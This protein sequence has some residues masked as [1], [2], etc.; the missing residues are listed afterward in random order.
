MNKLS[1]YLD[2]EVT[3]KLSNGYK[4]Q[5]LLQH[6][7]QNEYY[8]VL[9]DGSRCYFTRTQVDTIQFKK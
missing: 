4:M 5:G 9:R 3:I 7:K 2:R 8:L 6:Y 1:F